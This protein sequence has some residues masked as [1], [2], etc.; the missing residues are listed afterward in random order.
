[1]PILGFQQ[2]T[3]IVCRY[4]LSL[5]IDDP[6]LHSIFLLRKSANTVLR[7]ATKCTASWGHSAQTIGADFYRAMVATTSGE[8]L[9]GRRLV[10]NWTRRTISCLFLCRKLHLFL[11]KSTKTA[12]TRAALFD[13]NMHQIVCRRLW[14]KP[15]IRRQNH[16]Q[17]APRNDFYLPKLCRLSCTLITG[18]PP[19]IPFPWAVFLGLAKPLRRNSGISHGCTLRHADSRMFFKRGGRNR[20]RIEVRKATCYGDRK[21]QN[22]LAPFRGTPGAISPNKF[23]ASAHFGPT[24]IFQVSSKSI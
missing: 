1:M 18:F 8:K 20:Y 16:V 6:L 17:K 22:S 24:L 15:H 14:P 5:L 7:F 10:R 21:K 13:S 23:C 3:S 12:A 9:M 4:L 19:K 11:G 2:R